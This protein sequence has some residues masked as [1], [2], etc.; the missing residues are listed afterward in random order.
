M[1]AKEMFYDDVAVGDEIGPQE[2]AVGSQRVRDFIGARFRRG[3]TMDRFV[4]DKA[5]Q[6]EGLPSA[7]LPAQLIMALLSQFLTGWSSTVSLKKLD[8]VFRQWVLHNTPVH[9]KGII[10]H[11]QA[12]DGE[13]EVECDVF[14]QQPDGQRLVQAKAVIGLPVRGRY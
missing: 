5:A 8:V 11:K 14:I 9:F 4:D 1:T 2:V 3:P 10:T 6:E 13:G 7:V 12:N